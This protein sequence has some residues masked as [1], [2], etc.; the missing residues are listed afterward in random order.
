MPPLADTTT[1][2]PRPTIVR[3]S[4][5]VAEIEVGDHVDAGGSYTAWERVERTTGGLGG[6]DRT[7]YLRSVLGGPAY[8]T[9]VPYGDVRLVCLPVGVRLDVRTYGAA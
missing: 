4:K 9:P 1:A 6:R 5:L 8:P 7:L 3:G 2:S